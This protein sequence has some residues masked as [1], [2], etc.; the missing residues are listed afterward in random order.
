MP[1][2]ILSL[3]LTERF[4]VS[5]ILIHLIHL[6]LYQLKQCRCQTDF[7][8]S[9]TIVLPSIWYLWSQLILLSINYDYSTITFPWTCKWYW[10]GKSRVV[11]IWHSKFHGD[12][13]GPF[14]YKDR[15]YWYRI[16]IISIS[17]IVIMGISTRVIRHHYIQRAPVHHF[18]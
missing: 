2:A 18:E 3:L 5:S 7:C 4:E 17:I 1:Q 8:K 14:W 9:D 15:L 16:P 12:S 13:Y 10:K 6:V 11:L